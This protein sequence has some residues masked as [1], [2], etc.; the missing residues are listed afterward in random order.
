MLI[1]HNFSQSNRDKNII[2]IKTWEF[3]Q[4]HKKRINQ[5]DLALI[6][7]NDKKNREIV[8]KNP[9]KNKQGE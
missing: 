2:A 5:M 8:H 4:E 3:M 9:E 1:R 6:K 7:E